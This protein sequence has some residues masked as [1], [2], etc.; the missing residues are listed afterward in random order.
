MQL[1]TSDTNTCT[2]IVSAQIG[3]FHTILYKQFSVKESISV[4]L[5]TPSDSDG[6]VVLLRNGWSWTRPW[7]DV[8][9]DM[10]TPI[11]IIIVSYSFAMKHSCDISGVCLP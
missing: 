8:S 1:S 9:I 10:S 4:S 3:T 2:S 11:T 6:S 5:S 7:S